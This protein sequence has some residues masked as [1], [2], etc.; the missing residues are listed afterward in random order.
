MRC[1]ASLRVVLQG[2]N[3][4]KHQVFGVQNLWDCKWQWKR[5]TYFD[6]V[7]C[8]RLS[9]SQLCES[10]TTDPLMCITRANEK[11]HPLS[12]WQVLLLN[13]VA[14]SSWLHQDGWMARLPCLKLK[15]H[16]SSPLQQGD[17]A[18]PPRA[19]AS[20][21]FLGPTVVFLAL[22][23]CFESS[24]WALHESYSLQQL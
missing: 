21:R 4:N 5:N 16:H 1:L 9:L 13:R 24:R 12:P 2:T 15:S 8:L 22:S 10:R 19:M 23:S 11:V 3:A 7:G 14:W 18:M 6:L 17:T 20:L